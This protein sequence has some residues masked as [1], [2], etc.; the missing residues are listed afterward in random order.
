MNKCSMDSKTQINPVQ[1]KSGLTKAGTG[2]KQVRDFAPRPKTNNHDVQ[3]I[4]TADLFPPDNSLLS[5][6]QIGNNN[7]NDAIGDSKRSRG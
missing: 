2:R 3:S 6:H 5:T 1:A 7:M 4:V